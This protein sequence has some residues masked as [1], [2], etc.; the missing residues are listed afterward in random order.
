MK[1]LVGNSISDEVIKSLW[2]QRLPQ[3]TQAIF[4]I[5]NDT[6]DKMADKI[7]AVYSSSETCQVTKVGSLPNPASSPDRNKLDV[8]QAD[9]AALTKKI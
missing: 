8:L 7:I 1:S 2:L 4:S 3:Q 6:L 9:I 5:S